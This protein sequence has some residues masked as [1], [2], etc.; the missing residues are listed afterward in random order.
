MC[1]QRLTKLY[2]LDGHEESRMQLRTYTLESI[3]MEVQQQQHLDFAFR[4]EYS[5]ADEPKA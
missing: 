1:A 4:F 2:S 3:Y 5:T